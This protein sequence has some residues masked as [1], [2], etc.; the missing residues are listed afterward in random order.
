M[1]VAWL[2]RRW[3]SATPTATHTDASTW[4]V[5]HTAV[6]F[7]AGV[8]SATTA[9][10]RRSKRRTYADAD[11]VYSSGCSSGSSDSHNTAARTQQASPPYPLRKDTQQPT[12]APSRGLAS[13]GMRVRQRWQ[14]ALLGALHTPYL[15]PVA[16]RVLEK[17]AYAAYVKGGVTL[18]TRRRVGPPIKP[19]AAGGRS[20]MAAAGPATFSAPPQPAPTTSDGLLHAHALDCLYIGQS[21]IHSRG[22]FTS[23]ALPRGTRVISAP[24][25]SLLLAPDFLKLLADTHEKLPDT[26]YYTQPTG[27]VVE[28]VTQA[29]P[30]HLLNHSC[31]PNVCSGLSPCLWAAAALA[32]GVP[33]QHATRTP[34]A[35]WTERLTRWPH[36]ADAN[37]FFVTRDVAAG[38][39][40]TLDYSTRMAPMYA[41]E[42]ARAW[43]ARNWLTCRCGQPGCRYYVYRPSADVADY[44]RALRSARLAATQQR[45]AH[46]PLQ[47]IAELMALG[48]DDELVLLSY[49]GRCADVVAYVHGRPLPSLSQP[50]TPLSSGI[51]VE[52]RRCTKSALLMNY[53]H[54]F[55]LLNETV[56]RRL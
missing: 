54:V 8:A 52:V 22:L 29:Q 53:R 42:R 35:S 30:H 37:S 27:S 28:L 48:F 15:G 49:G 21:P 5:L 4:S 32:D 31:Q 41:G 45:R 19:E 13:L 16:V 40:L 43:Q 46:E 56:P 36:F 18:F 17:S 9:A 2:P 38:E 44:V 55:H 47:V 14:T 3:A 34:Q 10:P 33:R 51:D 25:R 6:R 20:E 50:G 39:E 11:A 1:R 24:R 26:W 23:K 12:A 7:A